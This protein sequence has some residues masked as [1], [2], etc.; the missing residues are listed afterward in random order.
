MA[1]AWPAAI[2]AALLSYLWLGPLPELSLRSFSA[3][4]VLHLGVAVVAAPLVAIGLGRIGWG[5]PPSSRP[6]LAAIRTPLLFDVQQAS[7]LVAGFV[8]W[9]VAFTGGSRVHFGLGTFSM[10]TTFMHMTML[11]VLLAIVPHLIYPADACRGLLGISGAADQNMGGALMAVA[12]GLPYL[13]GGTVLGYRAV[14]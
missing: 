2:G 14:S 5:M 11:G 6:W 1:A 8:V 7:F 9:A 13:L 3:H 4:M 10:L 12:G